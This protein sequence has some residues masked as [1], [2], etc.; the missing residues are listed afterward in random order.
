MHRWIY[1]GLSGDRNLQLHPEVRVIH[2]GLLINDAQESS[3]GSYVCQ[4]N[5]T[6]WTASK[7]LT[8]NVF[9]TFIEREYC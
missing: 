9:G 5:S 7:E 1:R 3:S 4:V 6:S 8:L 2:F